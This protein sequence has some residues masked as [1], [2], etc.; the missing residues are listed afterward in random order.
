MWQRTGL[1]GK[2]LLLTIC[3]VMLSEILILLPSL[4]N[5]W[6][7]RLRTHLEASQIALLTL[8]AAPD[9]MVNK[10]LSMTLLRNAGVSSVSS[11]Q[12]ER[13]T[14]A[15]G[16]GSPNSI[17]STI[18]LRT[19]A[20]FSAMVHALHLVMFGGEGSIRVIG[21]SSVNENERIEIV[22]AQAPLRVALFEF[23]ERI[24]LVS[25]VI[26]VLTAILVFFAIDRLMVRPTR[27]LTLSM[28][29]F[30][31]SP[32][33][34]ERV[35]KPSPR[36]DE[37]GIME[38][39][40]ALLQTKIRADLRR[41]EKLAALGLAVNKINHDLRNMLSSAQLI[42]DRISELEDPETSRLAPRLVA[43]IDRAIT[44]CKQT[45]RF[46]REEEREPRLEWLDLRAVVEE[47]GDSVGI[48]GTSG[49]VWRND[50][51]AGFRL[52]ADSE[53]FFRILMNLGRNAVQAM[54]ACRSTGDIRVS[55]KRLEQG[56]EI[57]V[58][59]SARG[60]S[61]E[62]REWLEK[63]F[64]APLSGK[65]GLGLTITRE[66]VRL[67]GGEMSLVSTNE[68]GSNFRITLPRG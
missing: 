3:F 64:A 33:D 38:Q 26:S 61:D 4:G 43:S 34:A 52:H 28:I 15:L 35:I 45:L 37:I 67:H 36:R 30:R 68:T 13:R 16:T 63:D 62:V 66:L 50:I 65:I 59:D 42:S 53:Q 22:V 12:K 6:E 10:E 2:L 14:L 20:N 24:F 46:G 40:L 5:Y 49:I 19:P 9:Y 27:R 60:V 47:V 41:R 25:S 18:D 1:S 11:K 7:N 31:E 56:V 23:S 57:E 51:E 8:E 39:E 32:D 21:T 44:L 48:A 55:A 58:Q 54:E 29:A 17:H